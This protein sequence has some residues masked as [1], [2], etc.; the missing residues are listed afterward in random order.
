MPQPISSKNPTGVPS[1]V[2]PACP[3]EVLQAIYGT[4]DK[5]KANEVA[6]NR[7]V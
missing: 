6:L 3:P 5:K 7:Y 1:D 2:N 4:Y